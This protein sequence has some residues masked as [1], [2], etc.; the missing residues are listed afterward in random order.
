MLEMAVT[1]GQDQVL[2]EGAGGDP[3]I[4][5]RGRSALLPKMFLERSVVSRRLGGDTDYGGG[6]GELVDVC[7]ANLQKKVAG[8]PLSQTPTGRRGLTPNGVMRA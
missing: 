1:D 3:D 7:G 5:L 4:I 6:G 8:T 2:L